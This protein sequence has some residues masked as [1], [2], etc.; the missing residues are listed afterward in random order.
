MALMDKKYSVSW[1]FWW[2][3]ISNSR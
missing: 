3:I 2:K 1:Y